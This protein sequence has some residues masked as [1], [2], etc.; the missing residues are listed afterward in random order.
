[1]IDPGKSTCGNSVG[2]GNPPKIAELQPSEAG[3]PECSAGAS[4]GIPF[5][6]TFG[7]SLTL[8]ADAS[9]L[10]QP[11]SMIWSALLYQ[12]SQ[13]AA[14]SPRP[15]D[16]L[17]IHA[18][19]LVLRPE[20]LLRVRQNVQPADTGAFA[21]S[22]HVSLRTYKQGLMFENTGLLAG[23][24]FDPASGK[25][26]CSPR[27]P[28]VAPGEA[29]FLM[30]PISSFQG[31]IEGWEAYAR[32]AKSA[33]AYIPGSP[34]SSAISVTTGRFIIDSLPYKASLELRL[35]IVSGNLPSNRKVPSFIL[36]SDQSDS[37]DRSFRIQS[38]SD[39]V[40]LPENFP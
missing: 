29:H 36:T 1:V 32:G 15:I 7:D 18:G 13:V 40:F 31:R 21:F 24:A 12:G 25:F 10:F 35:L 5:Q 39:S 34:Y 17:P 14:I 9:A 28:L 27:N 3:C 6:V 37:K 26:F 11:D 4:P 38:T 2:C 23:L 33:Y 16:T 30:I 8:K 19:S 22:I 20:D